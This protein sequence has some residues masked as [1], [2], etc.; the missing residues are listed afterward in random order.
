MIA[1]VRATL[2]SSSADSVSPRD[3][4]YQSSF[5]ASQGSASDFSLKR[6]HDASKL[7]QQFERNTDAA[8]G[9]SKSYNFVTHS[10]HRYSLP[11]T[12]PSSIASSWNRPERSVWF[13]SKAIII[14]SV[15]LAIFIVLF[16]GAAVFL[17]ER[18]FDAELEGLD[19]EEA[20]ARIEER[21]NMGRY[22]EPTE[23]DDDGQE[24]GGGSGGGKFKRRFRLGRKRSEKD[25]ANPSIPSSGSSSA[26]RRK[27]HLVSRWTR[28]NLRDSNDTMRGVS[29][30]AS[31]RSGHSARRV[32]LGDPRDNQESVEV[33]YDSDGVEVS[34]TD[35]G[36][37]GTTNHARNGSDG[38]GGTS[39]E[40][41]AHNRR[42]SSPP[43]PPHPDDLLRPVLTS[44][45][46][47]SASNAEPGSEG[48]TTSPRRVLLD[49]SD[50]HAAD[51]AE[52]HHNEMR[53][54]PPA[55][56]SSG[57]G[58]REPGY[59]G[60]AVAAAIARGD[61][62]HGI[63]PPEERDST[64]S[65]EVIGA[66]LSQE[67]SAAS[68]ER[69]DEPRGPVAAH[70]ATDDK[71]V[72][73]AL[74]AAASM[75]SAPGAEVSAPAYGAAEESAA[76]GSSNVAGLAAGVAGPSA[77]DLE[78][79]RDGFEISPADVDVSEP[80]ESERVSKGKA[81]QPATSSLLPAPPTPVEPAFSPFDQPYR[82]TR[83]RGV[84]APSSPPSGRPSLQARRSTDSP[85]APMSQRK[86]EKQR[87]A[88][89]EEHLAQLVASRPDG[90]AVPLYEGREL[91]SAPPLN[92]ATDAEHLP[93]YEQRRAQATQTA[94]AP[95]VGEA[96]SAPSAPA[97]DDE[98]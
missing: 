4:D 91:A 71:A 72:L 84:E 36:A 35:S 96:P 83:P 75:P 49:D 98:Q 41:S 79:D 54:M 23:K 19:D 5:I 53:Y 21:M 46:S 47:G 86:S 77:P 2:M 32:A 63:P 22:S 81:K 31:I 15:F 27:R 68:S 10:G 66:A 97:M 16:I 9:S 93:V 17:R 92:T 18:K 50:F 90:L 7:G 69:Y 73:G 26:V 56:I 6:E 39:T 1:P 67:A 43:P 74:S 65:P 80:V 48:S 33:T 20:L 40:S 3:V 14:T 38:A 44:H 30:S 52:T 45:A 24:G 42:R 57:S 94:S 25:D 76:G 64:V 37:D 8:S 62:K 88:E 85:A 13:Q 89:H 58:A 29:D 87:E 70:I 95:S 12:Y 78:V 34:R 28:G 61:A 51:A 11:S 60:A 82:A 55:Y 59:D